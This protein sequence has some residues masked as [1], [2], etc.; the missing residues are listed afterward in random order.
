M[1]NRQIAAKFFALVVQ[2]GQLLA[3]RRQLAEWEALDIVV[4]DRDI[5][6]VAKRPELVGVHFLLLVGDVLALAGLAHAIALHGL[7]QDHG[8]AA[9]VGDRGRIS[10]IN[11]A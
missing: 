5:E 1:A 4:G 8:R 10:S 3:A 11:L 6:A 9:L 2:I 7:G